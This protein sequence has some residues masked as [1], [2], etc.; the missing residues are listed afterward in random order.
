MS[1]LIL[2]EINLYSQAISTLSREEEKTNKNKLLKKCCYLKSGC[3][4][5]LD[6]A[7][8]LS[9][10]TEINASLEMC[11]TLLRLHVNTKHANV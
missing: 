7:Y 9:A 8:S 11:W 5:L 6:V 2:I 3:P 10:V 4:E 1:L